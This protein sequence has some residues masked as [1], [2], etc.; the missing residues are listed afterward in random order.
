MLTGR[1]L[2]VKLNGT[3]FEYYVQ[4]SSEGLKAIP[5]S[6]TNFIIM[7][8]YV[9]LSTLPLPK[10]ILRPHPIQNRCRFF[11]IFYVL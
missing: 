1:K 3:E 2:C 11:Y 6:V 7:S 9:C 4:P 8:N 10:F 5:H